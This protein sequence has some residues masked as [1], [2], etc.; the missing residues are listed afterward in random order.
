MPGRAEWCAPNRIPSARGK[1]RKLRPEG[2]KGVSAWVSP[3]AVPETS[4]SGGN[5]VEPLESREGEP[6]G[7]SHTAA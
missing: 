2:V 6:R 3:K 4:S 7:H 5:P 1:V